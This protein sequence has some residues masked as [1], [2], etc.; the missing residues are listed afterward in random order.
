[1]KVGTEHAQKCGIMVEPRPEHPF[2]ER[3][4]KA[5]NKAPRFKDNTSDTRYVKHQKDKKKIYQKFKCNF[6]GVFVPTI[7]QFHE[8]VDGYE[9]E[10]VHWAD[11][12]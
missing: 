5:K 11:V 12:I 4:L 7:Q 3:I 10:R 9:P 2:V 6:F 8:A 1:M